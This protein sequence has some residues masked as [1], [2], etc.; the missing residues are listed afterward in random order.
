MQGRAEF[1]QLERIVLHQHL[2][3]LVQKQRVDHDA[4]ELRRVG[5]PPLDTKQ[6]YPL[7]TLS[8]YSF[9]GAVKAMPAPRRHDLRAPPT[10]LKLHP[11][12]H[13]PHLKPVRNPWP[14]FRSASRS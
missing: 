13:I 6:F 4:D 11:A 12:L 3:Q 9:I 10:W 7:D 14:I 1:L 8:I 5:M 2:A